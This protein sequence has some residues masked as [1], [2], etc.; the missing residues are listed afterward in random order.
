MWSNPSQTTTASSLSNQ[1]TVQLWAVNLVLPTRD[2]V[3]Q[4][5]FISEAVSG[6]TAV[7]VVLLLGQADLPINK[8][9]HSQH[10]SHT[11]VCVEITSASQLYAPVTTVLSQVDYHMHVCI[12]AAQ[13]APPSII[14]PTE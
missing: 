12:C 8:I 2:L 13:V 14:S 1:I 6:V 5:T 11:L 7:A 3:A 10:Q 9:K 4:N